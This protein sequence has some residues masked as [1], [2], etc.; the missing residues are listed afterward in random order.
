MY[1]AIV[2]NC[3]RPQPPLE[4]L[5]TLSKQNAWTV[6]EKCWA[7][8]PGNRPSMRDVVKELSSLVE[9]EQRDCSL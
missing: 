4:G 8:V 9:S 6:A 5:G 7:E 2:V 3:L 1:D